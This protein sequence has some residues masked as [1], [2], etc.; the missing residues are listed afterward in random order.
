[1]AKKC[2][3]KKKYQSGKVSKVYNI[4]RKSFLACLVVA[5][6]S[7]KIVKDPRLRLGPSKFF[8]LFFPPFDRLENFP[9][10]YRKLFSVYRTS[11]FLNKIPL[12]VGTAVLWTKKSRLTGNFLKACPHFPFMP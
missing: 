6:K 3:V 12:L 4:R 11:F 10:S 9:F 1:M 5:K 7:L 8:R 2:C